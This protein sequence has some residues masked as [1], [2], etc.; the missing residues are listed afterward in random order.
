MLRPTVRDDNMA[1][2][3]LTHRH[4]MHVHL[5]HTL[6]SHSLLMLEGC[7]STSGGSTASH[8]AL[9]HSLCC[10]SYPSSS[11]P[12]LLG[13]VHRIHYMMALLL[14]LKCLTL[15]VEG[16]RFHYISIVGVAEAWSIVYYV[17]AFVKGVMLFT[18]IL[19][20]GS[21]WSLMKAYLNDRCEW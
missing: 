3:V 13:T 6:S 21:G 19:L 16:I 17:F 20:I 12:P 14:T 18:V 8:R 4:A 2:T 7:D 15:L 1:M 10:I 5:T 9:L 11:P